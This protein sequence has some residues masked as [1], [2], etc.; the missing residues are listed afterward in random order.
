MSAPT[1]DLP[2]RARHRCMATRSLLVLLLVPAACHVDSVA[3]APGSAAPA[4]QEPARAP[5]F[6]KEL[7]AAAA[8]YQ[9]WER[10]SDR[11]NWAPQ[12]CKIPPMSGVQQ[13]RSDDA[14]THGRKLYFL[15]A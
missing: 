8:G 13:S 2:A 9:R 15:F 4:P 5:A 1:G 11:A 12:M 10:V 7:L 14:D 3:I 6:E